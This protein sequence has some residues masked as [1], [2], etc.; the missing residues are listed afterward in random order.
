M[1][2]AIRAAYDA[3]RQLGYFATKA[4]D[5]EMADIIDKAISDSTNNKLSELKSNDLASGIDSVIQRTEKYVHILDDAYADDEQRAT[6]AYNT[7]SASVSAYADRLVS[8]V[9][10]FYENIDGATVQLLKQYDNISK[11]AE[12]DDNDDESSF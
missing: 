3:G 9:N 8:A 12:Q 1:N 7:W 11:I 2:S 6:D 5:A 10:D 4:V